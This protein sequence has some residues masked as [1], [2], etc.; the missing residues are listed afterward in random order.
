MNNIGVCGFVLKNSDLHVVG[1]ERKNKKIIVQ[2]EICENP[3]TKTLKLYKNSKGEYF[4]LNGKRIFLKYPSGLFSKV[5][6]TKVLKNYSR[7]DL[8]KKYEDIKKRWIRDRD[9]IR[10]LPDTYNNICRKLEGLKNGTDFR[11]TD[12]LTELKTAIAY[13]G[14]QIPRCNI[15]INDALINKNNGI[16]WETAKQIGNK[17]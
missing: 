17:Y 7:I 6:N 1:Y 13:V 10:I 4:N 5:N 16:D 14:G 11:I 3:K 12:K 2:M 9:L 8:I 15:S